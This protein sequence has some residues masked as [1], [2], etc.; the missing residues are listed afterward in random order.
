[1]CNKKAEWQSYCN[2]CYFVEN[3]RLNPSCIPS[4]VNGLPDYNA[5]FLIS[6]HIYAATNRNFE[7]GK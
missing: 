4:L 2:W 6:N 3:V 5:Q 7:A 1:M